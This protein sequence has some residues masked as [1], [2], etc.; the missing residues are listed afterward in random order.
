MSVVS[1]ISH[2]ASA[3]S[4]LLQTPAG[5]ERSRQQWWRQTS[6]I[7]FNEF[8]ARLIH[9]VFITVNLEGLL[10]WFSALNLSFPCQTLR[11]RLWIHLKSAAAGCELK[12]DVLVRLSPIKCLVLLIILQTFFFI[13]KKPEPQYL[14]SFSRKKCLKL[15][16]K[17][18]TYV[19]W[20]TDFAGFSD[21]RKHF[22]MCTS[23]L[24]LAH[25]KI[26]KMME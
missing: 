20:W 2:D 22:H 12:S 1:P 23:E 19:N 26:K 7:A 21:K 6:R 8:S 18:M 11:C 24:T 15:L 9:T 5:R 4:F 14:W 13:P 3:A 10:K 17:T 25:F 16:F